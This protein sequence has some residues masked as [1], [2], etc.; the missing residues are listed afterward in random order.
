MKKIACLFVPFLMLSLFFV[1]CAPRQK[2]YYGNYS[3]TLYSLQKEM[4]E[5]ALE[6]HTEELEK[7]IMVS[8]RRSTPVPPGI[9]AEL[10]YFYYKAGSPEK[11][12]PLFQA[13]AAIYPE[14]RPF[15]D[16]LISN[17]GLGEKSQDQKTVSK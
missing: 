14:S 9:N 11:A 1:G 13:E 10:G 12:L 8:E 5:D 17:L 2:Y 16:R 7:I 15:M 4:S 6:R 3:Q